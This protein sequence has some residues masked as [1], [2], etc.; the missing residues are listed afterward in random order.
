MIKPEGKMKKEKHKMRN[1][2]DKESSTGKHKK[3]KLIRK[4]FEDET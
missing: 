1:E 2:I 4:A 3:S